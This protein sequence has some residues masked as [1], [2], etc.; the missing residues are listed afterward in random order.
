MMTAYYQN[1]TPS[2]RSKFA[3]ASIIGVGSS[4]L[5]G[6]AQ[7][8]SG[9]TVAVMPPQNKP[10]EV[11]MQDDQVCRN[12][13]AQSIGVPGNDAAAES[14]A[15]STVVGTALGAAVGAATGGRGSTGTGAAV[16][17]L[18]GASVGSG[19]S[20]ATAW[21]AQRRYDIAYQQCMYSKG[22]LIPTYYRGYSRYPA[23]APVSMPPPPPPPPAR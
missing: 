5:F 4:V 6:C 9:P 22:N 15:A 16:G 12:W 14:F 13:A 17:A 10:F 19:Q 18:V 23:P 3:L 20:A 2:P 1:A 8:P 21:N 11:F 7:M